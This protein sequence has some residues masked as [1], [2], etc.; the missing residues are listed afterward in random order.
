MSKMSKNRKNRNGLTRPKRA[1][2]DVPRELPNTLTSAQYGG[3]GVT[4]TLPRYAQ[5]IM[6]H[7]PVAY[8][9]LD[10]TSGSV[11]VDT[12]AFAQN[13]TYIGGPKLGVASPVIGA[14]TAVTFQSN[15]VQYVDMGNVSALNFTSTFSIEFWIKATTTVNQPIVNKTSWATGAGWASTLSA[16]RIGFWAY[17]TGAA[18]VFDI[19]TTLTYNDGAWH[20]VVCSWDGTTGANGV[21]IYV[22]GVVVKQATAASGTPGNTVNS[23]IIGNTSISVPLDGSVDEVALYKYALDAATVLEHYTTGVRP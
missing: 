22:D 16:G 20:H 21:K 2:E 19:T 4:A 23:V 17:T 7:N 6:R 12:T 18:V 10:E 15:L 8:W 1:Y 3:S 9:R 14:G 5:M 13:G 11:A